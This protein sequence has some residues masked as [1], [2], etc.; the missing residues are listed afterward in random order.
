[1]LIGITAC[2]VVIWLVTAWYSRFR[3]QDAATTAIS[4]QTGIP[5]YELEIDRSGPQRRRDSAIVNFVGFLEERTNLDKDMFFQVAD[6]DFG[7]AGGR[8]SDDDVRLL[9]GLRHLRALNL[10]SHREVTDRSVAP[11]A[12]MKW[13][14]HLSIRRTSITAEGAAKL[15]KAL[16]ETAIHYD[17]ESE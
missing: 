13:L 1:M 8:M 7:C 17:D 2:C 4:N 6:I 5:I 16:P 15:Q 3:E 14:L 10:T 9:P 11:L 12:K